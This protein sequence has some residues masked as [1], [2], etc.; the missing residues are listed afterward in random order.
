MIRRFQEHDK[1]V[2]SL[3]RQQIV[4]N[5]RAIAEKLANVSELL[6]FEA[7]AS[8]NILI[9]QGAPDSDLFLILAG[10]VSI[11]VKGREMAIRQAGQH[12]GEMAM[13]DRSAPR[14][15][16]VTAI[17]QT[18][19]AKIKECD[20][21]PIADKHPSLW[22]QLALELGSRLLRA[23]QARQGAES[24]SGGFHRLV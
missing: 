7:V 14:S 3:Q 9:K 16:T 22:R 6:T 10:R 5:D 12:V 1:L 15:A 18:V 24:S 23:R 11:C 8:A 2:E 4:Q 17:E 13:I 21:S 20:F 19:V